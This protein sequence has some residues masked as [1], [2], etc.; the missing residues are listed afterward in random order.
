MQPQRLPAILRTEGKRIRLRHPIL[1]NDLPRLHARLR[2]GPPNGL[3]LIGRRHIRD[4]NSW[5]HNLPHFVRGKNRCTLRVHP[6]DA[7]RLELADGGRA[8][9]RSA[10][11]EREVDVQISDELMPGVVSLPHGFGHRFDGTG[12]PHASAHA[13]VSANDLVGF[14]LD[15]PSG[16]SVVNGVPVE[17][18]AVAT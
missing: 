6:E 17:V 15:M 10:V 18:L 5:L 13:G 2:E 12:Q 4:M 1:E 3:L 14:G 7:A 9:L 11:A 8:L 16:T